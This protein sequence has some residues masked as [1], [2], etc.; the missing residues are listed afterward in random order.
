MELD[1]KRGI[2]VTVVMMNDSGYLL[3]LDIFVLCVFRFCVQVSV[4]FSAGFKIGRIELAIELADLDLS[5]YLIKSV[6]PAA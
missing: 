5:L 6:L 2:I 4:G 3:P 1:L